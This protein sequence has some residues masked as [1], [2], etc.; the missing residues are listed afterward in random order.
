MC[1][2]IIPKKMTSYCLNIFI[3][4]TDIIYIL[5]EILKHYGLLSG[6][7]KIVKWR[8]CSVLTWLFQNQK[9]SRIITTETNYAKKCFVSTKF[10]TPD[11][12][13]MT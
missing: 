8:E 11:N 13:S 10:F 2:K 9:S 4:I 7:K 6:K 3:A 12:I 1:I 5:I